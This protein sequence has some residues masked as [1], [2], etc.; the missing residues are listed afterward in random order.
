MK[1]NVTYVYEQG[2]LIFSV[3]GN[4]ATDIVSEAHKVMDPM[5]L[6]DL[7]PFISVEVEEA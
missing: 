1:Y 7:G 4:S 6:D 3:E 5:S 2:V